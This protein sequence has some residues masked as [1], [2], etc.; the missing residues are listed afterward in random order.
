ME[1][2]LIESVM[3]GLRAADYDVPPT[4]KVGRC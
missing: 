1:P 2:K 3:E 4:A